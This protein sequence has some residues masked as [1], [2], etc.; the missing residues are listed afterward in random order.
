MSLYICQK[1]REST[2][3]GMNPHTNYGLWVSRMCQCRFIGCNKMYPS[4]GNVDNGQKLG[5]CGDRELCIIGT[6]YFL[7][8]FTVTLK[9]L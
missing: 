6:L 3:S 5:M 2:K 9:L 7:I 4:G 1:P 8:N